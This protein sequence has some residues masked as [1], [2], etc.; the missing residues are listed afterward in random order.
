MKTSFIKTI[1]SIAALLL[2]SLGSLSAEEKAP[3]A[4]TGEV[5]ARIVGYRTGVKRVEF[6]AKASVAATLRIHGVVGA[7]AEFV[8]Y[9]VSK[10]SPFKREIWVRNNYRSELLDAKGQSLDGEARARKT[11]LN[12]QTLR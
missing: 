3:A 12:R 9:P 8:D 4:P 2:A 10:D 1:A 7:E 11:R 6:V 5:A